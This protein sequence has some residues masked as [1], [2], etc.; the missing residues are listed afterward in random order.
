M[1]EYKIMEK[2]QFT[3][4]GV[5]RKFNSETSYQKI[6]EFWQEH[7][8]SDNR[9]TVCGMFGICIDSDGKEFEY[10]IADIYCPESEV[11]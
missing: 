4:I 10:L 5:S 2:E 6:P 9:K 11:P 1:L 8:N 3:V 7:M